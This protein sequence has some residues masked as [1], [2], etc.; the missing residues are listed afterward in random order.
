MKEQR[1]SEH[2]TLLNM[3]LNIQVCVACRHSG[4]HVLT[5]SVA[6]HELHAR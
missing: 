6:E 3:M 5:T 4:M 1:K 2:L